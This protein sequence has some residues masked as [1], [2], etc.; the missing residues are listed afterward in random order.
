MAEPVDWKDARMEAG[1]ILRTLRV[2]RNLAAAFQ[3]LEALVG[4]MAA[5]LQE[6]LDEADLG[7]LPEMLPRGRITALLTRAKEVRG[8]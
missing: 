2:N 6:V 4:E 8:G 5:E 3:E 1:H 7:E